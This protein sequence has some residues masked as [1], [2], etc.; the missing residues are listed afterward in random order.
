MLRAPA[1]RTHAIS[2]ALFL[3][4]LLPGLIAACGSDASPSPAAGTATVVGTSSAGMQSVRDSQNPTL[5]YD[6]R[7]VAFLSTAG[8][9]AGADNTTTWFKVFLKNRTT[10]ALVLASVALDGGPANGNSS[11]PILDNAGIRV[12]FESDASNLVA[13]DANGATDIFLRN[14]ATG[15]TL[16]ISEAD[17]GGEADGPSSFPGIDASG[18]KVVF[19]S[20][21]S[22][23]TAV[24]NPGITDIYLKNLADNGTIRVSAAGDGTPA[25]GNSMFPA[26]SSDGRF[27]LFYSQATNLVAGDANGAT[28]LFLK[29]LD[30]GAVERIGVDSNGLE[31][32]SGTPPAGFP[33]GISG[34]G[35]F[36]A[37]RAAAD[38]LVPTD[39][40]GFPDIFVRDRQ[41]GT[42]EIVSI[43]TGNASGNGKSEHPVLSADGRFVA[44]RSYATN[45]DSVPNPAGDLFV[46]D[47]QTGTTR[48]IGK[49]VAGAPANDCPGPP[50]ISGDG[51]GVSFASRATNLVPADANGATSDIFLV[52]VLP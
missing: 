7:T 46:R 12:A 50:A 39:N 42:V 37:F 24:P 32:P 5:S 48:R 33:G 25:N 45:F 26:I 9:L 20:A 29:N 22:N 31:I 3:A 14:V 40:N 1:S 23:L 16:R 18:G 36:V 52:P 47:R 19:Q 17:G 21:A 41:A 38:N 2:T 49:G 43:S 30:N 4:V 27:V 6:G 28:D 34:N 13:G 11:R 15:S 35:R 8:D 44:F 10:G 51:S